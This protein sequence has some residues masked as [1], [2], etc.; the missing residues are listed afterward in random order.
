MTLVDA[1]QSNEFVAGSTG[2]ATSAVVT[3]ASIPHATDFVQLF[4]PILSGIL[5][6][7][8]ALAFRV[9]LT[10]WHARRSM[11]KTMLL[12]E[13]KKLRHDEDVSNDTA[14]DAKE[15]EAKIIDAELKAIESVLD[16][17]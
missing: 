7:A 12:E 4:L 2:F 8:V 10:A 9:A 3:A 14:A 13:A 15:S 6:G 5:S 1:V 16:K 11:K 17:K